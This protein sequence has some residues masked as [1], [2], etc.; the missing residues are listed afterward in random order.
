MGEP[1]SGQTQ[2]GGL[3]FGPHGPYRGPRPTTTNND[4]TTSTFAHHMLSAGGL[5]KDD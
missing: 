3:S 4:L 1:R 5:A 2:G